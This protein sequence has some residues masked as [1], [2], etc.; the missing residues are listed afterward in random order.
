MTPPSPLIISGRT[1]L[2]QPGSTPETNSEPPPSVI[3]S[4]TA[5]RISGGALRWS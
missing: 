5:S 4:S 1:S 2:P 3:A